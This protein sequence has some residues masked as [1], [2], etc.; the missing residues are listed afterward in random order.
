MSVTNVFAEIL[1]AQRDENGDLIVTGKATGP[2]LDHDQQRCDA[3]WL[4]SAMPEWF[5]IGN[6]REQHTSSAAGVATEL[7]QTGDSWMVTA[8]VVDPIAAKKVESG[9]Y[10]G[11]SIGIKNAQVLK[12]ADAPGG[13]ITGGR[14]VEVSLTDRPCNPTCTLELAKSAM[15]GMKVKGS[16]LDRDRMLVKTETVVE[17]PE[18]IDVEVEITQADV[19]K[20]ESPAGGTANGEDV[21]KRDVSTNERKELADKGQAL[22]DGSFP[23]ANVADLKNAVQAIG[24]AK[25]PAKAKAH[26]KKRAKAL[27]KPDLV[28]DSW[29]TEAA[30]TDKSLHDSS[31]LAMIRQGLVNCIQAELDELCNGESEIWD[32]KELLE[33]LCTFL[34]WWSDEAYEGET[35]SPTMEKVSDG[36]THVTLSDDTEKAEAAD[37]TKQIEAKF[38]ELTEDFTKKLEASQGTVKSLEAELTK[39]KSLPVPGGPVL[40]RTSIDTAQA[41]VKEV[42]LAKAEMYEQIANSCDDRDLAKGYRDLAN[43]ARTAAN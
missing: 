8:K 42:N 7:E 5:K 41:K 33:A 20:M 16:D 31:E 10:K 14:I 6:I 13:L 11:Y 21:E 34:C 43:A 2:D 39:M 24:R 28:P 1:K 23:I 25:D 9:V 15:P 18:N 30:D 36:V 26:I 17:T 38:K 37:V 27:G 4:K 3:G 29:K 32:I 22:P 35:E 40:T 12:S 19:D